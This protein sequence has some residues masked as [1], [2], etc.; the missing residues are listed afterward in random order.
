MWPNVGEGHEDNS[1]ESYWTIRWTYRDTHRL[2]ADCAECRLMVSHGQEGQRRASAK[3]ACGATCLPLQDSI[4]EASLK[5]GLPWVS[6]CARSTL[7]S[8][9]P[10]G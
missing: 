5:S 2:K 8:Y 3:L 1:Q 4:L 6:H 9:P 10:R 7:Q